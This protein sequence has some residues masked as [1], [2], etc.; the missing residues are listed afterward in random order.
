MSETKFHTY[1]PT[2]KI[3][4]LYYWLYR[5]AEFTITYYTHNLTVNTLL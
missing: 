1:I 5:L 3:M 4:V 2:G